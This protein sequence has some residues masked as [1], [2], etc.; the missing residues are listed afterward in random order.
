M[1]EVYWSY[2][3]GQPSQFVNL[4]E[5]K[6]IMLADGKALYY[7]AANVVADDKRFAALDLGNEQYAP[8]TY[9]FKKN[10]ELLE[11]FNYHMAKLDEVGVIKYITKKWFKGRSSIIILRF[12]THIT[13]RISTTGEAP[14]VRPRRAGVPRIREHLVPVPDPLRRNRHRRN[15]SRRRNNLREAWK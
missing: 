9:A 15:P 7:A 1:H 3:D 13:R 12:P 11:L 4:E 6:E 10:S 2:I 5:G 14:R 8:M